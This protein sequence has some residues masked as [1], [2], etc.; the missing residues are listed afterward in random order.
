MT[1]ERHPLILIWPRRRHKELCADRSQ[2]RFALLPVSALRVLEQRESRWMA[3]F[4][5]FRAEWWR[6]SHITE[7]IS[8]AG[9]AI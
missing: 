9:R 4:D 8:E 7:G 5:R 1:R 3:P 6:N 2:C